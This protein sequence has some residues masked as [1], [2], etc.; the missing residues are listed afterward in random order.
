LAAEPI[1][2]TGLG[3]IP[4]L[5]RMLR[6]D[7]RRRRGSRE[8]RRKWE[9]LDGAQVDSRKLAQ[10]AR[11]ARQQMGLAQQARL[12]GQT[13]RIFKHWHTFHKPFALTAILAVT[14]HVAVVVW[15]GVTWLY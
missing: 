4:S 10:V 2:D 15:T 12:L 9:A 14:V 11:L 1:P 8:L 13:Q 6:D 3:L 7:F 5:M